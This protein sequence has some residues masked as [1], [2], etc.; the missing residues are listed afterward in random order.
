MTRTPYS[1]AERLAAFRR[2]TDADLAEATAPAV[3]DA[4]K[5][6]AYAHVDALKRKV[7]RTAPS[8]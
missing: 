3:P 8:S 4:I 5:A 7:K 1:D 2:I 6:D